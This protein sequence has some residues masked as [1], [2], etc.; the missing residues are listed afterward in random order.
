LRQLGDRVDG[1]NLHLVGD[2]GGASVQRTPEDV[3]KAQDVIDLIGVVGTA[4]SH[5]HVVTHRMR[6]F[7]RD[8]R[9]RI[10]QCKDHRA[11]CHFCHHGGLEHAASGQAKE[12][13]GTVD[14]VHQGA[15]IG[16]LRVLDLVLIHQLGAAFVDHTDDV[17]DIDV[18]ALQAHLQQ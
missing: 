6:V 1:G 9:V 2:R 18:L 5:D 7:G 11:R 4:S 14:D 15:C 3:R 16:L 13:I 10:G 8:F 17:G 12:H